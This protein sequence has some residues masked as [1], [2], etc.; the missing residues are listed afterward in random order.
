MKLAT[1]SMKLISLQFKW[2]AI[3]RCV[4]NQ[5]TET[6]DAGSLTKATRGARGTYLEAVR[7]LLR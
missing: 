7:K 6:V 5:S 1:G 4:E 2:Q 3:K